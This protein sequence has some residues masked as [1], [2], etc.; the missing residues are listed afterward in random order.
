MILQTWHNDRS[1]ESFCRTCNYKLRIS[2][3]HAKMFMHYIHC[4]YLL[5]KLKDMTKIRT[6]KHSIVCSQSSK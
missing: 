6:N 4:K 5:V 2:Y 3:P 1:S